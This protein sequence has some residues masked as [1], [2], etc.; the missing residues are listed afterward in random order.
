[1]ILDDAD[2]EKAVVNGIQKCYINCGQTCSALTRMLVPREKLE[3]VEQIAAAAVSQT[4]LGDPADPATQLGPLASQA[5]RTGSSGYIEKGLEEGARTPRRRARAGPK[6]ST[7]GSMC[8][9]P[10]SA[11]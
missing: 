8:D 11:M 3:I 4:Q 1:M 5:Q 7:V 9:R 6:D 2:L 10:C